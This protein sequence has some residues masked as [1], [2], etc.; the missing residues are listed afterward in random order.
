MLRLALDDTN[1]LNQRVIAISK[2]G[3]F[4]E[5]YRNLKTSVEGSGHNAAARAQRLLEGLRLETL[6]DWPNFIE[7]WRQAQTVLLPRSQWG[8]P[9]QERSSPRSPRI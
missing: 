7:G 5:L 6:G 2:E 1:S 3:D 9:R 8:N 4:V